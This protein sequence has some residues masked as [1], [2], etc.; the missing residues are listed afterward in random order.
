[1]DK[2][3]IFSVDQRR[4][5]GLEVGGIRWLWTLIVAGKD[6]RGM[7]DTVRWLLLVQCPCKVRDQDAYE[8]RK[9]RS[10]GA[11]NVMVGK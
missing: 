10:S 7:S 6:E 2:C 1:M 11:G 5:C 4:G 9:E 8:S 3:F